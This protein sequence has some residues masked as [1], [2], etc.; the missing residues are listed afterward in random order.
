MKRMTIILV[1]GLVISL[2]L[3]I[4][5][6]SRRNLSENS[7][8]ESL[9]KKYP[10]ISKRVLTDNPNDLLIN[11]LSLR[12]KLKQMVGNYQEFFAVYFEYLPTGTSIGINEKTEFSSASLIKVPIVMAYYHQKERLGL[13]NN[14]VVKIK[15]SEI[16]SGF[17]D[18]WKK[19]AGYEISLEDAA[20]LSLVE[21]DNT[22]VSVLADY[23]AREDF[24]DVYEG[25]DINFQLVGTEAI[26]TAKQYAS[27]LK[28]LYFA[29]VLSK[30]NSQKILD[31][32]TRTNFNDK[33]RA[34]VPENIPIANK[35]G[36]LGDQLFQDCGIVYVPKRPYVVC[37]I[38][39]TNED[40]ARKRMKDV[41][42]LIYQFVSLANTTNPN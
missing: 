34:G 17:G 18:L 15:E 33:L 28:A 29:S 40:L 24:D 13:T 37:M 16:D 10:Y 27:I 1:I 30:D 32:L 23:V 22:A 42:E 41:S 25:L 20:R 7:N 14:Q 12:Q 5:L 8:I 26:I 35:F 11:F 3:N 4:V 9:Y 6:Y 21:S 19:G 39:N 31:L 2:I 38:S 36:I